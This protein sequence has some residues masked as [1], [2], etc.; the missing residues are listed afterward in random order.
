METVTKQYPKT[1]FT[2]KR[3]EL[4]KKQFKVNEFNRQQDLKEYLQTGNYWVKLHFSDNFLIV[5]FK[6][7]GDRWR[8]NF[9]METDL[10]Y[11][12]Y[13]NRKYK[14]FFSDDGNIGKFYYNYEKDIFD[15]TFF[16]IETSSTT[17]NIRGK[18]HHFIMDGNVLMSFLP[19]TDYDRSASKTILCKSDLREKSSLDIQKS[20]NDTI[21]KIKT[22]KK[23]FRAF[24]K[25][26]MHF[27]DQHNGYVTT[28]YSDFVPYSFGFTKFYNGE[29]SY[30]GGLI[31]HEDKQDQKNSRY[32]IHT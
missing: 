29:R 14:R 4:Q 28:L 1:E 23:V 11:E 25:S 31:Y 21:K 6:T 32:G 17:N 30:N 10:I 22:N 24:K 18:K 15:F 19:N 9:Y 3:H 8:T 20:A 27:V 26:I 16:V 5:S 12:A 2:R 13:E 7:R